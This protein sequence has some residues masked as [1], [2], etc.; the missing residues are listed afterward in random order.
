MKKKNQRLETSKMSFLNI[1]CH[2]EIFEKMYFFLTIF[3]KK[4]QFSSNIWTFKWQ[5]LKMMPFRTNGL[6]D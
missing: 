6:S 2:L 3:E 1:I 4:W 5:F